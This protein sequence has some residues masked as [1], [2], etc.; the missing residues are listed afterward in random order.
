[1]DPITIAADI[2]LASNVITLLVQA[3]TSIAGLAPQF[4]ALKQLAG[5]VELTDDQR[6]SL[7]ARH[8]QLEEANQRPLGDKPEDAL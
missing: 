5:G 1:M 4:T 6:A 2:Q 7:Q 8:A 3:G